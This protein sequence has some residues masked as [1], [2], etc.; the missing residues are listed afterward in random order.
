VGLLVDPV[1]AVMLVLVAGVS[2]LVQLYSLGYLELESG[3]ALGRYFA[4][5]SLFTF[6]MIGLVL[7][8]NFLQMFI[9]WE[10][11]GLCSYLLIGFWYDRPAAA[12]AAMKAFWTT[13][14]GDLGFIIGIVENILGGYIDANVTLLGI[15]LYG[16]KEITPFIVILLVL[17]IRPYGLFGTEHIERL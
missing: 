9:F 14:V 6:S 7:A 3:P 1:A 12:R 2:F 11:V 8:G 13:K 10:L 4:Y 15:Q 17:L 5:H 16:F